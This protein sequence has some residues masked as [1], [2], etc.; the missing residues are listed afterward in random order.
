MEFDF[1]CPDSVVGITPNAKVTCPEYLEVCLRFFKPILAA[2]APMTAQRNINLQVLRPLDVPV[3]PLDVQ[4]RFARVRACARTIADRM[5]GH[6]EAIDGLFDS[7]EQRAFR[8][9]L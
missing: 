5:R 2:R 8:G 7:L 6:A 3:P 9:D 4:V 1:Y